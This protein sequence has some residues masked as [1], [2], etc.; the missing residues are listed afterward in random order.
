MS[1]RD[2][3]E[4]WKLKSDPAKYAVYLARKRRERAKKKAYETE[5]K[6]KWRLANPDHAQR[7]RKANHAVER[8]IDTGKL[9]RPETCSECGNRGDI[10]AHHH[11]GYA[12]EHWL[13][14]VWLCVFCHRKADA[15]QKEASYV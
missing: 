14:I 15:K 5:R 9:V 6:R 1:E 12:P 2:K 8:A 7:I 4:Y 13:D 11:K 10:E 3:K